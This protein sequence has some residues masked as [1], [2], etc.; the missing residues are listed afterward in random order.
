M[1]KIDCAGANFVTS[2]VCINVSILLRGQS[3]A[4]F[5][6]FRFNCGVSK[7]VFDAVERGKK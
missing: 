4:L 2:A 5:L 7:V 3:A 6:T 1:R